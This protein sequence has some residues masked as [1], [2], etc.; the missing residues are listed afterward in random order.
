LIKKMNVLSLPRVITPGC[1]VI[2]TAA[3]TK[4]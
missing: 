3:A 1:M 4:I 2:F